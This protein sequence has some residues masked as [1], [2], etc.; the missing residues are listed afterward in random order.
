MS[1]NHDP[2]P[3]LSHSR[4]S[5]ADKSTYFSRSIYCTA[6]LPID[7]D[8][9]ETAAMVTAQALELLPR[10]RSLQAYG[11]TSAGSIARALNE[12]GIAAPRGGRWQAVQVQRVLDRAQRTRTRAQERRQ[13]P[14]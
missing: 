7:Q 9:R 3:L 1:T 14:G 8:S 13:P 12:Q 10:I 5:E 11:I 6:K 2:Y 4:R